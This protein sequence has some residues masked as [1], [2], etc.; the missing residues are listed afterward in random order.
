MSEQGMWNTTAEMQ[1]LK[2]IGQSARLSQRVKTMP[3]HELLRCYIEGIAKRADGLIN[4]G[5]VIDEANRMR[6]IELIKQGLL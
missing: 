3:K 6:N 5:H 2:T 4:I 1:Y